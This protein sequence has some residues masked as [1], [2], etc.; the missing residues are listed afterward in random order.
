MSREVL[1]SVQ[2]EIHIDSILTWLEA[3]SIAG[4]KNWFSALKS[5]LAWL[6]ENAESCAVAPENDRFE[7]TIQQW[8]FKTKRGRRYRIL[9]TLT[10][11]QVVVL[12]VRGPGR[13]LISPMF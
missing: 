11:R 1:L 3:R 2:A 7:Q 10:A 12:H 13:D 6:A 8:H 5:P 4:A 9:F